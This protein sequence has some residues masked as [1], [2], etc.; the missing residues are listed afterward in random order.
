[1]KVSTICDS[2]QASLVESV[3]SATASA[4]ADLDPAIR[5]DVYKPVVDGRELYVKFT[6]DR[7]GGLLLISFKENDE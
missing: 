4:I 7:Q 2:S 3:P 6:R 1:M 5:P